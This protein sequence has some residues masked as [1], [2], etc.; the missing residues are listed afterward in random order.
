MAVC[1]TESE[2]VGGL[3]PTKYREIMIVI[4]EWKSFIEAVLRIDIE[5]C[6]LL[7]D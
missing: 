1:M 5:D 7:D 3:Q 4:V 2:G 6:I